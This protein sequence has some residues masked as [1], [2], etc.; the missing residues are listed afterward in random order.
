[1]A[2]SD[3]RLSKLLAGIEAGGTKF[4]CGLSDLKLN[5]VATATIPTQTPQK[6]FD[7]VEAFFRKH[8]PGSIVSLGIASF[9]PVGVNAHSA[10]YGRILTTPKL[11]WSDTP[12]LQELA[13]RLGIT[14]VAIETDVTGAALAEH[15]RGASQNVRS[16][17]YVTIGTG[18]GAGFLQGGIPMRT[19]L[20]PEFGHIRVSRD[21]ERDPYEGCCPFHGDC[22]E[23][24]AS[25]HAM[26]QRWSRLPSDLPPDHPAWPMEV[27]YIAQGLV[28]L[29]FTVCPDR[30]V[31]GGGIG[32]RL[33][34]PSVRSRV[35]ELLGDYLTLPQLT[36]RIS[37]YIVP[38]A[39]GE[40]AGLI[41]ALILAQRATLGM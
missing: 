7:E 6:T 13:H 38:P 9:G 11:G 26:Q 16:S 41:G 34:W 17:A 1:M 5:V 40:T 37:D 28:N 3:S 36:D 2:V 24:L 27:E 39:L 20:H 18:I 25:G 29:I 30:V 21:R 33:D 19:L 35:R 14:R 8:A 31:V 22:L 12:I 10:T 23:G 32:L 15:D 4:Q